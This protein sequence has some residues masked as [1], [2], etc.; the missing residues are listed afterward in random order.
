MLRNCLYFSG[1]F[2]QYD[3]GQKRNLERYGLPTPPDYNLTAVTAPGYLIY[4]GN[5]WVAD[6]KID[7]PHLYNL[8]GNCLGT[9]FIEIPTFNHLDYLFGTHAP[10]VVYS[11]LIDLFNLH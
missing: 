6:H 1:H 8:L 5:D 3:L 7:I 10:T 11:T 2:R 4:A 9:F